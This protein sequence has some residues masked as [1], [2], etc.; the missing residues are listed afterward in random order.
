MLVG[1]HLVCFGCW[2]AVCA[3]GAFDAVYVGIVMGRVNPGG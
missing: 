3:T 2:G 1:I